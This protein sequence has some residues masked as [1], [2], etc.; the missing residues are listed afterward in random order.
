M[1]YY[2]KYLKY[3]NKYLSIKNSNIFGGALAEYVII[4][5]IYEEEKAK[6]NEVTA[7]LSVINKFYDNIKLING[8]PDDLKKDF[9]NLRIA[10]L[11]TQRRFLIKY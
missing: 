8:E 4:K 1:N 3:K 5:K 10:D 6:T 7:K 11:L 2:L 9:L